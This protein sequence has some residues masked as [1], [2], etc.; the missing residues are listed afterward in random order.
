MRAAGDLRLV[1][2]ETSEIKEDE[3]NATMIVVT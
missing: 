2:G 3:H 1:T